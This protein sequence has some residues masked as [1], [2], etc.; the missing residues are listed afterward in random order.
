MS[1]RYIC[2]GKPD[3]S[4]RHIKIYPYGICGDHDDLEKKKNDKYH[5][6]D[7]KEGLDCKF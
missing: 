4:N 5:Q 1:V 3:K 6:R 2:A 7:A